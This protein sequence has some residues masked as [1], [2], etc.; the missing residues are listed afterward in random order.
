MIE[1]NLKEGM[2]HSIQKKVDYYDS[3]VSF[4][5][6]GMETLFTTPSLVTMMI[7]AA[8]QLVGKNIPEGFVS[9]VKKIELSHEKPTLQGVTVTI[10]ARVKEIKGNT[11]FISATCFDELGEIARGIQERH[12][13][14]KKALI[15]RAHE[16][17]A[18]LEG[19]NR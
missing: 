19:K 7:E 17:A 3:S 8:V 10:E 6:E 12:I 1:I 15:N 5:R 9:V 13:V 18:I 16:R 11:V 14:N 4:G 2:T